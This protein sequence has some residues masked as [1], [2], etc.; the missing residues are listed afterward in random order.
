MNIFKTLLLNAC[1]IGF[2]G[3][4]PGSYL[5]VQLDSTPE[6]A[7]SVR[8]QVMRGTES[9]VALDPMALPNSVD[10]GLSFRL[11]LPSE[12]T[13][14]L[15]VAV[16]AFDGL[17]GTGCLLGGGSIQATP[18]ASVYLQLKSFGSATG[19][20]T[21]GDVVVMT[22]TPQQILT[23]SAPSTELTLTGWGFRPDTAIAIDGIPVSQQRFMSISQVQVT[24]ATPVRTGL[25]PISAQNP[26]GPVS[27]TPD[28]I[29]YYANTMQFISS[30]RPIVSLGITE[31]TNILLTAAMTYNLP[32]PR[33]AFANNARFSYDIIIPKFPNERPHGGAVERPYSL[34]S[35]LPLTNPTFA[36][37]ASLD[38]FPND[39]I[40]VIDRQNVSGKDYYKLAVS[41]MDDPLF[42]ECENIQSKSSLAMVSVAIADFNLD[43]RNDLLIGY[44]D[45]NIAFL[46]ANP[47]GLFLKPLPGVCYK[48]AI[49]TANN[50]LLT[51]TSLDQLV[52]AR[53][54][55]KHPYGMVMLANKKTALHA[56]YSNGSIASGGAGGPMA[57]FQGAVTLDYSAQPIEEVAA[58]DIDGDGRQDLIYTYREG[59]Q[60]FLGI[61][62]S[63]S[64]MTEIL[65]ETTPVAIP[66]GKDCVGRTPIRFADLNDDTLPDV[67]VGC[68]QAPGS[69]HSIEALVSQGQPGKYPAAPQS[70]PLGSCDLSGSPLLFEAV[71]YEGDTRRD[72]LAICGA[73]VIVLQNDSK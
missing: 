51:L 3:C 69:S 52:A 33:I 30:E 4:Q 29:R 28:L 24:P 22:A 65:F 7:R 72:L 13:G 21:K 20:C 66:F 64:T 34:F 18:P 11:D 48:A 36:L 16:S 55:P 25:M 71:Q 14:P 57:G 42:Y 10:V 60:M 53:F 23:A 26:S 70:I 56:A 61:R 73:S 1:A 12:L 47:R 8:V 63:A 19:S 50:G 54:H 6:E 35:N 2:I 15:D 43:G 37:P 17:D 59:G 5:F 62:H 68:A 41:N 46:P 40:A 9:V 45:G 32:Y 49:G 44:E 27:S 38:V 67:F 39:D 58:L 31:G